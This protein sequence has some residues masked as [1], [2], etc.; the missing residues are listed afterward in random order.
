MKSQGIFALFFC[1]ILWWVAAERTN[2]WEQGL[3]SKADFYLS[4]SVVLLSLS[5]SSSSF[6]LHAFSWMELLSFF[7]LYFMHSNSCTQANTYHINMMWSGIN[8]VRTHHNFFP[9]SCALK[10][11]PWFTVSFV[12]TLFFILLYFHVVLTFN[13][14]LHTIAVLSCYLLSPS[15]SPSGKKVERKTELKTLSWFYSVKFC[16]RIWLN[17]E[18]M[19]T[20]I[21]NLNKPQWT[22]RCEYRTPLSHVCTYHIFDGNI[23]SRQETQTL[24]FTLYYS[25][26]GLNSKVRWMRVA[27]TVNEC[28]S[29]SRHQLD[30]RMFDTYM[31]WYLHRL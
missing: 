3:N 7:I 19:C 23:Y 4:A 31:M 14:S 27:E 17:L 18:R 13:F 22:I 11:D 21:S 5:S 30:T 25:P 2:D 1:L 29:I 9:H 6:M 24:K 28:R 26:Q 10:H 15:L 16:P 8:S 20:Q 12:R